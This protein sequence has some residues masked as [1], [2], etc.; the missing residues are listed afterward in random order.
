[1]INTVSFIL[2]GLSKFFT[3]HLVK[4]NYFLLY[5]WIST[6]VCVLTFL[7]GITCSAV[8]PSFHLFFVLWSTNYIFI[9]SLWPI[10]CIIIKQWIPDHLRGLYWSVICC[11]SSVGT[12]ICNTLSRTVSGDPKQIY[13]LSSFLVLLSLSSLYYLFPK[14]EK[15]N[16][17]DSSDSSQD[18]S[19][20]TSISFPD[21]LSII[22]ILLSVLLYFQPAPYFRLGFAHVPQ[23][24]SQRSHC[25]QKRFRD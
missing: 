10:I 5:S 8:Y 21:I 23:D 11:C 22:L 9:G 25:R 19:S 20:F 2:Y 7:C 4:G 24:R 3:S 6:V 13:F 17:S 16:T 18:Y 14:D 1:M 12:I 15:S